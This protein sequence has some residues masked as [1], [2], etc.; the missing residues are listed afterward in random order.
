MVILGEMVGSDVLTTIVTAGLILTT[1]N[2]MN[3]LSGW[4]QTATVM[5]TILQELTPMHVLIKLETRL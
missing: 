2:P 1:Q 5:V 4:I 3:R